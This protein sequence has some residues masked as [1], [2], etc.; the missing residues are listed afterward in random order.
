MQHVLKT[1]THK[2][3][4]KWPRFS[5]PAWNPTAPPG[6]PSATNFFPAYTRVD[7]VILNYFTQRSGGLG[8]VVS[9]HFV[10]L[11][12]NKYPSNN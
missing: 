8:S 3:Q 12:P 6:L 5:T 7:L 9:T 4:P 11:T 2:I 1:G 10:E